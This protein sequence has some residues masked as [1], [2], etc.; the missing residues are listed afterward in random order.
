MRKLDG[1]VLS[2]KSVISDPVVV[3]GSEVEVRAEAEMELGDKSRVLLDVY[4][5][6]G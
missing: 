1:V 2:W 6:E 4:G 5:C 3:V